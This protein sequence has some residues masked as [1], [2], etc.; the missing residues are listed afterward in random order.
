M[1]KKTKTIELIED[2]KIINGEKI[3][4]L[5]LGDQSLGTIKD[6]D[7]K[8]IASLPSGD[9]FNAKSH[10]EAVNLLISHYHLHS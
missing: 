2:E 6:E 1:S 3:S 8:F 10:E 9:A 7:H 5:K 4:E